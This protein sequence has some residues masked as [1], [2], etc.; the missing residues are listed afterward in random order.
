MKQDNRR[1]NFNMDRKKQLLA[2]GLA[3]VSMAVAGC[4]GGSKNAAMSTAPAVELTK[5][6]EEKTAVD[7]S[8]AGIEVFTLEQP[9]E[10]SYSSDETDMYFVYKDGTWLDGVTSEIPLDQEKMQEMTAGFLKLHAV[11]KVEEDIDLSQCGFTS[12]KYSIS[13]SDAKKGLKT[14]VIGDKDEAGNYYIQINENSIYTIKS[15]LAESLIFDYEKLV[16]KD[17]LDISVAPED[18]V[19]AVIIKDGEAKTYKTSDKEVMTR[20]A[21]GLSSLKPSEYASYYADEN[22]LFSRGLTA[23]KRL[24]LNA[25]FNT[26]DGVRSI[27]VYAGDFNDVYGSIRAVQIEGS[28]MVALVDKDIVGNLFNLTEEENTMQ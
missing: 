14:M 20:I 7:N 2:I 17:S 24:V 22:E 6:R 19:R 3:A 10:F 28:S 11:K 21:A 4:A 5:L 15:E 16:V 9:I 25:E 1:T 8:G 26:A 23:D 12:P 13:V 27:T 18:M